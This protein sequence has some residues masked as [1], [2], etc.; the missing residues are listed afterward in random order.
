MCVQLGPDAARSTWRSAMNDRCLDADAQPQ[1]ADG[2][3]LAD[4]RA[5]GADARS[6]LVAITE[7]GR[8]KRSR[9]AAPLARGAGELNELLGVERV[10]ALHALIDESIALLQRAGRPTRR[11]D[12]E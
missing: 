1:A 6:R 3:G 4:A 10:V 12:D 9:G 7:A 2:R 11:N 8:D 5:P